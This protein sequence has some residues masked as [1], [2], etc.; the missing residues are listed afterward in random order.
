MK[1][2]I[3]AIVFLFLSLTTP[4]GSSDANFDY[5]RALSGKTIVIIGDSISRYQYLN[6]VYFIEYSAWPPEVGGEGK[7]NLPA[8]V[9]N[10]KESGW[11]NSFNTFFKGSNEKLLGHETCDCFRSPGWVIENRQYYNP[12]LDTTVLFLWWAAFP[13]HY[14]KDTTQLRPLPRICKIGNTSESSTS[15][16][17]RSVITNDLPFCDKAGIH[18]K[19]HHIFLVG[20]L[21]SLVAKDY[22]PD[23]VV[24][25]SGKH[26]LYKWN[27]S[28]G[29]EQYLSIVEA[30]RNIRADPDLSKIKFVWKSTTPGIDR[31]KM[32]VLRDARSSVENN[33]LYLEPRS[34]SSLGV[35]LVQCG[36]FELFDTIQIVLKLWDA[37]YAK[38]QKGN[39][40]LLSSLFWDG[41]HVHCWVYEEF[42]KALIRKFLSA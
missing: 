27:E 34:S 16:D 8:S 28:P 6:L 1:T 2:S 3:S 30:L 20:R 7:Y 13:M 24:M 14:R 10:E 18:S 37:E 38:Y 19:L 25:N 17:D 23:I 41:N 39:S 33:V 26:R 40:H 11:N 31:A 42:N 5:I 4:V 35:K 15:S 36:L 29:K 9:C 32:N 12:D 22:Q 21:V